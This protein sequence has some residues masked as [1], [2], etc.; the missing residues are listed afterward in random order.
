MYRRSTIPDEA[1]LTAFQILE[2]TT[3]Q[4]VK[5]RKPGLAVSSFGGPNGHGRVKTAKPSPHQSGGARKI[6]PARSSKKS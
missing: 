5:K 6:A 1:H 2:L 4:Y 3:Q